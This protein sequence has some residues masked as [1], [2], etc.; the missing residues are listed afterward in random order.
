MAQKELPVRVLGPNPAE[1]GGESVTR[2][3]E[4]HLSA[5]LWPG[6]VAGPDPALHPVRVLSQD[7]LPTAVT[8]KEPFFFDPYIFEHKNGK[9]EFRS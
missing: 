4:A 8:S 9:R 5:H 3:W 2:M 1:N 7:A 6:D